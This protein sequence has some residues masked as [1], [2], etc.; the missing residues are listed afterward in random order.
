MGLRPGP[1]SRAVLGFVSRAPDGRVETVTGTPA[2]CMNR[3]E[4]LVGL[5]AARPTGAQR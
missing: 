1:T 2:R 3:M 5:L 4:R